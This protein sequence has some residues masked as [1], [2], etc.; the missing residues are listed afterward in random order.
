MLISL[1]FCSSPHIKPPVSGRVSIGR[2]S[3]GGGDL[4]ASG[5]PVSN[6]GAPSSTPQS[7]LSRKSITASENP[8]PAIG[9]VAAAAPAFASAI[10]AV[11]TDT[12]LPKFPVSKQSTPKPTTPL[13]AVV[14]SSAAMM[15]VD[16]PSSSKATKL[17]NLPPAPLVAAAPPLVN[18]S[19][20]TSKPFSVPHVTAPLAAPPRNSFGLHLQRAQEL[21]KI[22]LVEKEDDDEDGM[23]EDIPPP[24][25]ATLSFVHPPSNFT[26]TQKMP[27]EN[28]GDESRPSSSQASPGNYFALS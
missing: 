22:E 12:S 15:K 10:N 21:K 7:L 25:R 23:D 27:L 11:P 1:S 9:K 17:S 6:R 19:P 18:R 20:F 5:T 24:P 26:A 28:D 16:T 2:R 14:H 8:S 13:P 3:L 4:S